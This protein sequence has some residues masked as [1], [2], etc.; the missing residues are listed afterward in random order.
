MAAQ[1]KLLRALEHGEGLP[2]GGN[3]PVKTRFR[4]VA[5]THQ[6][7]PSRIEAGEFR[8][9]LYFRLAA[10][11]IDIPPLRQRPE[12]IV[13]LA[14]HFLHLATDGAMGATALS[15][16]TRCELQRRPWYGNVRELRNAIEHAVI[17]ARRGR[18]TPDHLPSPLPATIVPVPDRDVE[19]EIHALLVEWAAARL[20]DAESRDRIYAQLLTLVE[21]PVLRAVLQDQKGQVAAAARA[22]GLHRTTLRKK[23][24]QYGIE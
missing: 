11:L 6:D 14:E 16:E 21:P 7:L 20:Q 8:H 1:V 19:S 17:V 24:D 23:L 12:D 4:V 10:F 9:D 15:E 22:L 3:Q 2:V 13:P 5:A 18:I